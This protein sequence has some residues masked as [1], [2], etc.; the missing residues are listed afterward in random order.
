MDGMLGAPGAGRLPAV[1]R[2][3]RIRS[4]FAALVGVAGAGLAAGAR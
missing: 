1:L 4:A 2:P 3:L